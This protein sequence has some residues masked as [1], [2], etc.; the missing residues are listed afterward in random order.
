VR[1]S[2]YG[3]A[4]PRKS[5]AH[6]LAKIEFN[7]LAVHEWDI[8]GMLGHAIGGETERYAHYRPEYMRAAA[9][10]VERLLV[11][12][13]PSWLASYLPA[14]LENVPRETQVAVVNGNFGARDRDRTCD[15]YHVKALSLEDFQSLKSANDD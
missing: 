15:P 5:C 11:E 6:W 14:P 12:I 13:R 2:T 10:A 4:A 8:K 7:S 1:R 9:N 3:R